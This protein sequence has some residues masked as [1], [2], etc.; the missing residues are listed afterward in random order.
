MHHER[1]KRATETFHSF[2][3]VLMFVHVNPS[4]DEHLTCWNLYHA[5]LLEVGLSQILANLE[6]L[7]VVCHVGIHVDISSVIMFLHPS[8]F[9]F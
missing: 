7:L 3:F 4:S 5:C 9:T 8:T 6:S 2:N 1:E